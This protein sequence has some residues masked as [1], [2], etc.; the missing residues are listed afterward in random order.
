VLDDGD[1]GA[2][3]LLMV[4]LGYAMYVDLSGLSSKTLA[5]HRRL[6]RC[7]SRQTMANYRR[8]GIAFMVFGGLLCALVV[9]GAVHQQ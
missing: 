7:L 4:A 3:A 2:T 5:A 6:R 8:G 9:W 1:L